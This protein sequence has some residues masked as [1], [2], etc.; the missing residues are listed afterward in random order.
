MP[1]GF[2]LHFGLVLDNSCVVHSRHV[3]AFGHCNSLTSRHVAQGTVKLSC[4]LFMVFNTQSSEF[5]RTFLSSCTTS[6]S[7]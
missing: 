3:S 7:V 1:V 4:D 6:N 2:S 5:D